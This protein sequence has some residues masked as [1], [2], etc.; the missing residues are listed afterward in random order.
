MEI[1]TIGNAS[2]GSR[3]AVDS[4]GIPQAMQSKASDQAT[5][6]TARAVPQV[7][8]MEQMGVTRKSADKAEAQHPK[9]GSRQ[10]G[11]DASVKLALSQQAKVE[12]EKSRQAEAGHLPDEAVHAKQ[13]KEAVQ[14]TEADQAKEVQKGRQERAPSTDEAARQAERE[15]TQ[16]V[17]DNISESLSSMQTSLNLSVDEDLGR[18]I[19]KV[20]DP[21]TQEI[22]KQFP[23]EDAL[24]LAKSL[25]RMTGMFVATSA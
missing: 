17:V 15:R 21:E 13:A 11:P 25:G 24:K 6:Q 18:V 14:S 7:S 19:V 22:L 9:E 8:E 5:V 16:K 23:S 20:V 1:R 3:P 2:V 4:G 10:S 12:S